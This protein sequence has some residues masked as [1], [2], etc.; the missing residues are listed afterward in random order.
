MIRCYKLLFV[1]TALVGSLVMVMAV[2][3]GLPRLLNPV[4]PMCAVVGDTLVDAQAQQIAKIPAHS[5][6]SQPVV[7]SA[8]SP[9]SRDSA[10][11]YQ[12]DK[13]H[14]GIAYVDENGNRTVIDSNRTFPY[15]WPLY[16]A[17]RWS[18]DGQSFSYMEAAGEIL[19][20]DVHHHQKLYW[21]G[22]WYT[23]WPFDSNSLVVKDPGTA[24]MWSLQNGRFVQTWDSSQN[25]FVLWAW[26]PAT[27][28]LIYSSY[29]S[30]KDKDQ[31]QIHL[32]S[33]DTQTDQIIQR[34]HA[35]TNFPDPFEPFAIDVAAD[36]QYVSIRSL[37]TISI[38]TADG[39]LV[40]TIEPNIDVWTPPAWVGN[41]LVI[42]TLDLQ[43]PDPHLSLESY[44][45]ISGRTDDLGPVV[46]FMAD[47]TAY[48]NS[49]D[50]I[51]YKQGSSQGVYVWLTRSDGTQR[52]KSP[53]AFPLDPGVT[54]FDWIG[55][56]LFIHAPSAAP[57]YFD[58]WM[59]GETGQLQR[60]AKDPGDPNDDSRVDGNGRNAAVLWSSRSD[61]RRGG[62]G[63]LSLLNLDSGALTPLPG[64]V[65]DNVFVSWTADG[66]FATIMTDS[67][68]PVIVIDADGH[69]RS[70]PIPFQG[71]GF[72][73]W[74]PCVSVLD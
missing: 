71:A 23:S 60:I 62:A 29:D 53:V 25:G 47:G 22:T 20:Y 4:G 49:Q 39:N 45:P 13:D 35:D 31:A 63:P 15:G 68:G 38:Y 21:Q 36:G 27:N 70:T 41:R 2:V 10:V 34:V 9:T 40:K 3:C 19:L 7:Y 55:P 18:S 69:Q 6:T 32:L 8:L 33:L 17:L 56:Y 65:Y 52:F 24:K 50:N 16:D 57:P 44:D 64:T 58:T 43:S 37:N 1:A 51:A 28:H 12:I 48:R 73:A 72:P 5:A 42:T 61:M 26:L 14:Y 46:G 67:G 30:A 59:N 11:L 66:D 74:E 54:D